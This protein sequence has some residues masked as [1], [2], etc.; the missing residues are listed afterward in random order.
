MIVIVVVGFV[1]VFGCSLFVV[2]Y[3]EIVG[4]FVV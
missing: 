2:D 3:G 1:E 4:F